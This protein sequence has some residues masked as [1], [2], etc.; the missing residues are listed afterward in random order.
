MD[1]PDLR[2]RRSRVSNALTCQLLDWDPIGPGLIQDIEA[3]HYY[4]T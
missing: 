2:P 3:G 1:R 4:R